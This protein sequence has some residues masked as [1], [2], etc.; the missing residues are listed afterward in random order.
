MMKVRYGMQ[1][2]YRIMLGRKSSYA[3]ELLRSRDIAY[4]N[5]AFLFF[6]IV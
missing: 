3:A 2:Y 1:V 5:G 6:T 4:S